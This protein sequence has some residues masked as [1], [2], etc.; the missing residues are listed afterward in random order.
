M[1]TQPSFSYWYRFYSCWPTVGHVC[2][3]KWSNWKRSVNEGL[4]NSWP[5]GL[6]NFLVNSDPCG[7]I[8]GAPT[9][10]VFG[11]FEECV[12][13]KTC[14]LRRDQKDYELC[15]SDDILANNIRNIVRNGKQLRKPTQSC[16]LQAVASCSTG[17]WGFR[18]PAWA[19]QT[20]V[21]LLCDF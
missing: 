13:T 1:P 10:H 5:T 18:G 2:N 12:L 8:H 4:A 11:T 14:A 15:L 9:Y 16:F 3:N 6:A 19:C 7:Y 21:K 20:L 17:L